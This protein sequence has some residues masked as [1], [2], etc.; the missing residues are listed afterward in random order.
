MRGS[1]LPIGLAVALSGAL[2][3]TVPAWADPPV[4]RGVATTNAHRAIDRNPAAIRRADA[5]EYRVYSVKVDGNGASH[6]RYTRTYRDL[7]VRGGDFVVHLKPGG[8]FDGASVGLAAPL[9][10]DTRPAVSAA[11]ASATAKARFTGSVTAV[12]APELL[13][14]AASGDGRLAWETTIAGWAPDR[15]TPAKLHVIVDAA[16]GKVLDSFDE[17]RTAHEGTAHEKAAHEAEGTGNS[18][19]SGTVPIS[20][21]QSGGS[22]TLVDP[23]HGN[24]RTCDMNN[25]QS[26][27]CTTFTDP[28]DTWGTGTTASRQSAA[29]DAH[30]G[31]AKTF[32]YFKTVHGR[33][34]IFG[35]GRGVPSR[36]HYGNNYV[37]AFWDGSQMTYGDGSGNSRPLVSLD[38]A[39]HE[40]SH[41]VT[42]NVV[43]GGLT[44][45]GES[46][47]LNEASSDIFGN[48]MEF[49]AANSADPGD[50]QVG[51]KININGNGTP[52]R[53]MYNPGLDGRSHSCWSTS[54]ASVDVHYSSGV[55][56]HFYF[57]LAEG[58]GETAYGT[59]P[60]CGSAPA[61]TGIGRAKAEK[62]WF[63]ALDLYFT[64]NTRYVSST[65]P[66]NTA[67][68]YTLRAATDL[69]GTCSTEY[70]TV[71]AAW[72]A[73][74]VAGN[75]AACPAGDD[76]SLATSPAS[77]STDPG[78]AVETTVTTAVTSGSAQTVA[79]TASGLPA[80]ATAA[81][82]PASVT[83]GQSAKLTITTSAATPPGSAQVTVTGTGTS[84]TH[85]AT[86]ALRVNGPSGGVPDVS[87]A[88]VKGHLAQLQ[89]IAAANGGNRAHGRPGYRASID[90]V[91]AKLDAAGF[92]TALQSFTY[93]GATGYNLLAD[94]PG[95]DESDTLMVG[96]HLDSVSAG[97][98]INDNGS[99]SAAILEVALEVSRASLQPGKHLR[100]A[101]WGA[102][103]HGLIGSTHYVSNLAAAE[104]SK[105]KAYYNFDMVGSPNPG[106]FVYDGDNSDGTGSGPGP[107]GSDVLERVLEDY[108][109]SISVPTRGTDFDG[110]SDYGPFIRYGI[111]AGGTFTGAEGI[112][113]AAQA[114]LWGGTAGQAFDRCYHAA[115]DTTSNINDTA[116]DRNSDAIAHAVWTV[117]G[118]GQ[119]GDF[120]LALAPAAGSVDPGGSVT[121][122]V[123]TSGT[124]QTIRLTAAGLPSGATA[125]F[126]PESV[127]TGGSSKLTITTTAATPAGEYAVTISGAGD[128]AT[129]TARF[130][131][132][133][134]GPGGDCPGF[135][136][137][138]TGTLTS[139][140]S[141]YQPDGRYYQS[142]VTGVHKACLK[143]PDGTDYDLYLQK[144]NGASWQNVAQ[145]TSPDA[146]EALSYTG[147]AGYYR[148]RVHSYTG[149]GA[150]TLGYDTP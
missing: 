16:N 72:T 123:S 142:T 82:D 26:G 97:P 2:V 56:N 49:F 70:R 48:M 46:G 3:T 39:G 67:R 55:A 74:N 71:Q 81:F 69:F 87:V 61:V 73:V 101:W 139:G 137:T 91:K 43:P 45:S 90:H 30:Y 124:A 52:L 5:D 134:N 117:A 4:D 116:L 13:V 33:N 11:T 133:V 24:G 86:Y 109:A 113:S 145:S 150:Y 132:T 83:A 112:K 15:Q 99:G 21:T 129:R 23:D 92:T 95:G 12:G 108:F 88:N 135:E 85:T 64:S 60:V 31:A 89:S 18:L 105:I 8:D 53:Y 141:V 125:A 115:C 143:G 34:G 63:R 93:G 62:I 94:W 29:V 128:S 140:Q 103:E 76:F 57:D 119:P 144:W 9:T 122:T 106:Y 120:A 111:A 32:D 121:S 65:N 14:D 98:G 47:G 59:S 102:E 130:T 136:N 27:S 6:I 54:T 100:F 35:D 50:Y 138:K 19:Y 104:R 28:D 17:I 146:E 147:T 10:L 78:G 38:V 1:L 127:E 110:R 96:A 37:N 148:Y 44:Y 41:G 40:M 25:S 22:Y 114:Q 20:T 126:V 131:L 36:V 58:T 66:G 107:A 77:G 149:T 51:E 75:D 68:A 42:E 118:R 7:R 79:L 80:G 84:R